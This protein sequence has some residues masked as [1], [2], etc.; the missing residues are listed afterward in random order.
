MHSYS[1]QPNQRR[2]TPDHVDRNPA[3]ACVDCGAVKHWRE[4]EEQY[5]NITRDTDLLC[6][7]CRFVEQRANQNQ[8]ITTYESD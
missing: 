3:V 4:W 8:Q 7:E 6:E 1:T 2:E 5:G